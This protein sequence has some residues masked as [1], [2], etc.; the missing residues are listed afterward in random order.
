MRML[1]SLTLLVNDLCDFQNGDK[2]KSIAQNVRNTK[3]TES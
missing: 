1:F 2:E 3:K